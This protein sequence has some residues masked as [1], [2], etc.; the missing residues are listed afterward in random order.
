VRQERFRDEHS[1]EQDSD[2]TPV[3]AGTAA[4]M[5]VELFCDVH[6]RPPLAALPQRVGFRVV[7]GG[8]CPAEQSPGLT[9]IVVM[10]VNE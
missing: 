5:R 3:N 4:V 6:T 2:S 9:P 1:G 8:V 7:E 10:V